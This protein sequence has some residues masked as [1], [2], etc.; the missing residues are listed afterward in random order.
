MVTQVLTSIKPSQISGSDPQSSKYLIVPI[1]IFF[2]LMIF[3]LIRGPQIISGSGIGTAIMVS[4]PLILATYALTALAL[5]GR[6]TVDLSMGPLI[7]F[8]NVTTIQ[9]YGAGYLQSPVSYFICAIAIGVIYQFL[10]SLI[11]LFVRVQPII[12]A[13]SMFLA[14][15]GINLVILPRPGGRAPDWMQSW[16]AGTE[17]I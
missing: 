2:A 10:Y 13:L 3:A 7:G 11:V 1:F 8:I 17:V 6:V 14:F 5:S 9:L 4:T 16:S 12:V 15:S